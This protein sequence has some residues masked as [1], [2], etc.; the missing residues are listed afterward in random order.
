MSQ[1]VTCYCAFDI[2]AMHFINKNKKQRYFCSCLLTSAEIMRYMCMIVHIYTHIQRVNTEMCMVSYIYTRIY[3][4]VYREKTQMCMIVCRYAYIHAYTESKYWDESNSLRI[5]TY[6]HS[7]MRRANIV[8]IINV[9]TYLHMNIHLGK[10][11]W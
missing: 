9:Y 10:K 4:C 8:R 2:I 1:H 7:H 3:I 5:Y 11:V 6:M